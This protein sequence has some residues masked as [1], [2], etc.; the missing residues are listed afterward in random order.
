M[1]LTSALNT[2]LFGL[3]Y[4]QKQID[5]T[6]SNIANADT[7]GYTTKSVSANVFFDG[8]GNVSGIL[9]TEVRRAVDENIQASY[10]GSLAETNYASQISSFTDRLDDLFGTLDDGSGLNSLMTDYANALSAL[11]NDPGGNAAQKEVVAAADAFA[12][13]LNNSYQAIEDMR[14]QADT[15]LREQTEDVND[16][17]K[18]IE[19]IDEQIREARTAGVSVGDLLDQRDRYVE[20]LSGYL[21]IEVDEESSGML[22]ITTHAGQQLLSNNQASVLSFA[23]TNYLQPGLSGNSVVI[24]SAA[25][26]TTNL[27][28]G[29][30][31]GSMVA[32]AEMRDEVLVEAQSQLDTIAAELS[33]S[34]SNVTVPGQAVTI[35]PDDGYVLDVSG[36]QAGNTISLTYTDTAGDT[37]NVTFVAVNDASL[38]PLS[39][40]TTARADDTVYGVDISSGTPALYVAQ[41]V[42]ALG[43]TS[44]QVSDDGSGNLQVLGDVTAPTSVE[45]LS[46]SVTPT[47]NTD[48]GL[49]L[50]IFVDAADGEE[51]FTD[52]LENGGQR[53]GYAGSIAVNTALKADSSLLVT[54]Q[55]V[56]EENSDNDA[57]RAEYLLEQL[58]NASKAFDADAG[59]GNTASP[60]EGTLM[61]YVNQVISY[62]GNQASDASAYAQAKETLTTNLAI[63]YEESYSVN[64]DA[65]MAFLIELE[66]AY[67]ANARVMQA[68]NEL[69]DVLLNSV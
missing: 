25:G 68:V 13:Q 39:D 51:I 37:Q 55:T 22:R 67:A 69:F 17:L 5:V 2:A 47:A 9:S 43:A 56:P 35:A 65:E 29:S 18:N 44:L 48:Q 20:Q 15:L 1:G 32:L 27:I 23:P 53:V 11:V 49:G 63:R 28:A 50:S 26:T 3:T 36:L 58:T 59:I 54:Y 61:T 31:S 24:T 42:A 41:I 21:D 34:M 6:A 57:S 7:A 60:Y 12:R 64:V 66:N 46:A 16:L 30:E 38:L 14:Q 45:A 8:R 4:N 40:D 62:Q 10:F 19:E 33:L 52:A